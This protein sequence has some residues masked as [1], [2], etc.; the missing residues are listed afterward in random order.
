VHESGDA[1]YSLTVEDGSMASS[2]LPD[3]DLGP[4]VSEKLTPAQG[5]ALWVD[6]ME[7]CDQFLFAGLRRDVGPDGDVYAAYRRWHAGQMEEHDRTMRH[8]VENLARRL[9]KPC[10]PKSS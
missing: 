6:L 4:P 1:V 10:P 2:L 5:I 8:M 3:L 9:G 7:T